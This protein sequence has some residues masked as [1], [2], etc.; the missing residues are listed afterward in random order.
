M[1][2]CAPTK[3]R[4]NSM[5][6]RALPAFV[7]AILAA[8]EG[9]MPPGLPAT[10]LP[11]SGRP[12]AREAAAFQALD[13]YW[14]GARSRPSIADTAIPFRIDAELPKLHKRGVLRGMKV[15]TEA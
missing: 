1:S 15:I 5:V 11:H 7:W 14:R 6:S 4:C 13:R 12:D 2:P 8:A 9:L 3:H 10:P